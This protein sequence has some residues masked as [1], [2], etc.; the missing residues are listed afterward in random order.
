MGWSRD[1]EHLAREKRVWAG[2]VIL[3]AWLGDRLHWVE[4][5]SGGDCKA[6]VSITDGVW[7][8][9]GLGQMTGVSC[10]GSRLD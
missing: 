3:G 10:K 5:S 7:L 2:V 1:L 6:R 4:G 9:L 8:G